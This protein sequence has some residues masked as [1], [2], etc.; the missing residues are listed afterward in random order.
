MISGPGLRDRELGS[1]V[2]M[3]SARKPTQSGYPPGILGGS[4]A[5]STGPF[6]N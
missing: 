5:R 3:N 4:D 1:A 6:I 2:S